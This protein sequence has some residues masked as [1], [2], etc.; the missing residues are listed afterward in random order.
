MPLLFE[1]AR[2]FVTSASGDRA[3]PLRI[4][5]PAKTA[6]GLMISFCS[7]RFAHSANSRVGMSGLQTSLNAS[8][9]PSKRR[10]KNLQSKSAFAVPCSSRFMSNGERSGVYCSKQAIRVVGDVAIFVN[11]DS[12]D[13]WTHRELFRLK[14]SWSRK[15][16]PECHRTFSARP[17]SAGEIRS[18]AGM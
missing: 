11:H 12:A 16:W 6:G 1:A 10:A 7:M 8:L 3:A 18:I 13:V 9:Q 5:L 2:N 14:K 4:V 15:S 17:G